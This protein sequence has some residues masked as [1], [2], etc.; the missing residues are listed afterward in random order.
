MLPLASIASA[1]STLPE[2]GVTTTPFRPKSRSGLPSG[3]YRT[4][5]KSFV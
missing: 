4:S 3:V 2:N 5:A 1:T